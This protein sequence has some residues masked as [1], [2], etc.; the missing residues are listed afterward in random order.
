MDANE[1]LHIEWIGMAQP[2]GLVV[3]SATLKAAEAN[4]TWPVTELQEVLREQ[5]GK[6][7]VVLDLPCFFRDILGWSDEFI[8]SGSDIPES[9]RITIEG[10]EPLAP[11]CAVRSADEENVFVLLVAEAS[12]LGGDLD[13]ASD[14]K[15]W[16]ASPHQRFERLLRETGVHVGLL[17]NGKVFRVVYAPKGET[18]G[19]VT[20]RLN[21]M[22]NVDGRPL[23]GALHMLLNERRLLSLEP[24][25]RLL[26][27]LRASREYQNT[28]SSALREQVLSALR[29]LLVGFQNADRLANDTILGGYRHGHLDEVCT[30]GS[31][32]CSCGASSCSS[33]RSRTCSRS[34]VSSMRAATL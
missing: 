17:T 21:E 20:F 3:T 7:K 10:S 31:S 2:Q 23:L 18:A 1:R 8:I 9:L 11:M 25:K 14:D 5:A 29:V 33:P 4:I 22:L 34:T 13:A 12:T 6:T 26:G 16:S 15:R 32:P 24:D 19:W 27:L 30:K 28:V